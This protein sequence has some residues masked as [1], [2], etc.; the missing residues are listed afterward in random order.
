MATN[1]LTIDDTRFVGR[2]N[3]LLEISRLI[4]EVKKGQGCLLIIEGKAGIGKTRLINEV[5]RI[6][7]EQGF[8]V[9]K[10]RCLSVQHTDP[11]MPIM[12]ALGSKLGLTKER[13]EESEALPLGLIGIVDSESEPDNA[14]SDLPLGL[15]PITES[16]ETELPKIDLQTERGKLFDVV[17]DTLI[18]SSMKKPIMFFIDDVQWADTSTLQL[19]FYLAKNINSMRLLMCVAYR[20]EELSKAE[21]NQPFFQMHQQAGHSIQ[22][23]RIVLEKMDQDEI[24]ELIKSIL[25]VEDVPEKFVKKI[26]EESEGNPFFVV[27]VLRSFMDERI[28]LRHGHIW[29]TGI[30][31]SSIR[32]PNTI[33]DV[34]S[35]RIARLG[36]SEKRILKY[37]SVIGYR[38]TF[39]VLKELTDLKEAELIDALDN[40]MEAD[41]VQE[42]TGAKEE[43]FTFD[44][45][46][47]RSVIYE[48]LSSSRQR[49]MHKAVGDV[50]ERVYSKNI[51]IWTFELAKHFSLGKDLPK[52]YK[53]SELAGDKAF[54]SLALEDASLYYVT[55]LKILETM[56]PVEG[57]DTDSEK[58]RLSMCIGNLFISLAMWPKAT[59]NYDNALKIAKKREDKKAEMKAL[60][61][62]G[63]SMHSSGNYKQAE[64]NYD[65]AAKLAEV[66]GDAAS[67]AEVQRGLGYVHWR[68][69]ETAE[70]IEHYN[71]SIRHSMKAGDTHTMAKTFIEIGNVY[72]HWGDQKKAIEYYKKS[73]EEL[74]RLENYY[75]LARA[76]NNLGDSYLKLKNWQEAISVLEKCKVAAE[77]IG[78]TNL[79]AWAQFNSAEAL[80]YTGELDRAEKQCAEA[81]AICE[82]Q[83]DRIGMVGVFRS[84]GIVYREKKNWDMSVENFN[85]G[86]VVLEMLNIPYDLGN[87]YFELGKTYEAMGEK[88][89]AAD[90]YRMAKQ[91][92]ETVGAKPEAKEATEKIA[93]TSA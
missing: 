89:Y 64:V 56:P 27:E 50:I 77:K 18:E 45:K 68:K 21:S 55:A 40:L 7:D 80:A 28:I 32:I 57:L 46:L 67:M 86:I 78:N 84:L 10:G 29:D 58:L 69:G 42:V 34:I 93:Q 3:H 92:F 82:S 23:V 2:K 85:K 20:P 36:E 38:Y 26:Y 62:R 88:M 30:D 4:P 5:G 9:L 47:T 54:R 11:Y 25:A 66:I 51:D 39:N 53:Y 49:M 37:A 61:A 63:Q 72:N 83:D 22:H 79:V 33:R 35:N 24:S 44:N 6:A 1:N 74:E 48:S 52:A 75:E 19:L 60:I 17:L 12:E 43:E 76:Y 65:S 71:Q 41:I 87:I 16:L 15:I 59:E 70:A 91:L 90:N 81:L 13:K 73:L 31:I 8:E 14:V